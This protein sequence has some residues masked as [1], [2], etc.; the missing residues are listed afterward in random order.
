MKISDKLQLGFIT[1][2]NTIRITCTNTYVK[3]KNKTP[4]I[5]VNL[6]DTD[7]VKIENPEHMER[8]LRRARVSVVDYALTNRFDY[9]GTITFNSKWHDVSNPLACR[10]AILTAFNNY[11]K[12]NNCEFKYLLVAEYGEKTQR[13]HFHFLISGINKDELFIN[14]HHK[15]DW[16]YTAERFGHTQ[17]T[18]IGKTTADHEN[19]ARYRDDAAGRK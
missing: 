15:L 4:K 5:K 11:Q 9:F 10:D 18:R 19:V 2:G 1:A 7:G 17:I 16:S 8:S 14:K 13:L 12:R 3:P 6:F